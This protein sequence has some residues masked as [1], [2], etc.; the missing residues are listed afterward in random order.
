MGASRERWQYRCGGGRL[1][2]RSTVYLEMG[3]PRQDQGCDLARQISLSWAISEAIGT[4]SA[5]AARPAGTVPESALHSFA[6][7]ASTTP[8]ASVDR[9]DPSPLNPRLNRPKPGPGRLRRK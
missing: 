4:S 7:A 1:D 6:D 5:L 2:Q 8:A 3:C 9:T